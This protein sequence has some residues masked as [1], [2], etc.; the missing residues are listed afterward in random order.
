MHYLYVW[1]CVLV[2]VLVPVLVQVRLRLLIRPPTLLYPSI[3]AH[4]HALVQALHSVDP[5]KVG[6]SD[7]GKMGG[8]YTRQIKTMKR[9]S[10]AQVGA[11]HGVVPPFQR[12]DELLAWF[13]SNLPPD[14]VSIV[15]GD[16]KQV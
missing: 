16:Y 3:H 12:G 5:H 6:L 7:Y 2:L 11:T 13:E 10:E 8:F 9:V 4:T 14:I 15:H 1:C